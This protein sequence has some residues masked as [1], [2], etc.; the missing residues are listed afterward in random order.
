[1]NWKT[2]LRSMVNMAGRVIGPERALQLEAQL[3]FKKRI[4]I[5][6]PMTL[7][8]KICYLEFRQPNELR[9][10]CSDKYEVRRY[11]ESKGLS[12]FL[13][14]LIG[15]YS[16]ADEIDFGSLPN[17]FVL[18][19]TFGCQ[20]NLI[21][22]DKDK[23]DVSLA[24]KT[25]NG[26]I[27]KGFNR[28]ALEP[29]YSR[30]ERRVICERFLGGA[31]GMVDYKFHCI[32]GKPEFILVCSERNMGVKLNL[33]DLDWNPIDGLNERRKNRK[34]MEKPSKLDDM[35][36]ISSVLAEDFEFARVDLYQIGENIFFGELTFTP[37]GGM[38]SN[39]THEFDLAMGSK[40]HIESL[41][42]K[43]S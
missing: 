43:C 20:M 10:L 28:S 19:A 8:D 21:C 17:Q 3:R 25:V 40:M 24:Y 14:P 31:Q 37:N 1:M 12:E 29:H 36:R 34:T 16:S 33:Y 26:W 35:I 38:L 30:L 15:C 23:L 42:T 27:K 6:N 22:E 4:D 32:N 41:N 2:G 13:V 39:F 11:V 7:S 9:A 5:D 18:K